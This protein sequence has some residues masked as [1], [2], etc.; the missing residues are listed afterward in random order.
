MPGAGDVPGWSQRRLQ[1]P[2]AGLGGAADGRGVAALRAAALPGATLQS[3]GRGTRRSLRREQHSGMSLISYVR[4]QKY[5]D[6]SGSFKMLSKDRLE[7]NM[8][9]FN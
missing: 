3:G 2:L 8:V 1:A 7:T 4:L 9:L 5:F 6:I